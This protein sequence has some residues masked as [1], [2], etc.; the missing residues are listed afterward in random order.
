MKKYVASSANAE[1]L[2]AALQAYNE[3][4]LKEDFEA[5][6]KRYDL[7]EIDS[8]KWYPQQLTLDIQHEIK[9]S[10]SGSNLLSSIGMKIIDTAKFPPMESLEQA[11]DAFASSYPMNFRNQSDTDVIRAEVV[12]SKQFQVIN[13]SPHSD[14]M[15]YGYVYAMVR[16]FGS[17]NLR[18]KVSFADAK[19]IDADTDTIINIIRV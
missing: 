7:T 19:A 9:K 4:F 11:L 17:Q 1:V 2:G 3:S 6:L 12:T 15:I 5:V 10:A 18:Y 8:E 13:Q 16:R 14:D